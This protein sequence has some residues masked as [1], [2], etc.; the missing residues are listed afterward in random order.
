[1][2]NS[3]INIRLILFAGMLLFSVIGYYSKKSVNPITGVSQHVDISPE[4]E[5]A[6]GLQSAP[7]MAQEYGG[8]YADKEAQG[9]VKRIGNKLVQGTESANSPYKFDFHLLADPETVNA[10]ALPG[11]QIFITVG[12][13]KR[14][15]SEDQIAGVLGHEIGHVVNRHSA[16][17]MAKSSL[18]QGILNAVLIG[19]QS[20]Q[21]AQMAQQVVQMVNLGYGRG[22]ELE[23]DEYGVKYM[24]QT[25]YNPDAM[26]DV[27]RIL[28]EAAGGASRQ[29]EFMSS[30]PDPENRVAKIKEAIAK[31][32]GK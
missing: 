29:P 21:T 30:H 3:G 16:Q 20:Q 19:A 8:L 25:G 14:L 26:I 18:G 2:Q 13:L 22:D 12:L 6:M 1:M 32:R 4:Q 24:L 31:Y 10:F 9:L 7:Q 27:M 28:K 17:Q 15:S 5:V 11:G 23:S